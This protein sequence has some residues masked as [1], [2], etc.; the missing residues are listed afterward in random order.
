MSRRPSTAS[1]AKSPKKRIT[2]TAPPTSH[3]YEQMINEQ[4]HQ[5]NMH[6][7]EKEVEIERL[8]TTVVALN[9]K[10]AIVD[11][12]LVDVQSFT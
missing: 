1:P 5:M 10:N 6:V 3:D 7:S 4:Q 2:S 12:H 8:M 9:S 11:D